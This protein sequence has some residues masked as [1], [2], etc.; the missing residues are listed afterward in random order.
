MAAA[1]HKIRGLQMERPQL[2]EIS[3]AQAGEF[4]Q[5]EC[6]RLAFRFAGLREPVEGIE[7]PRLSGFEDSL[8][9]GIQSVCSP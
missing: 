5:Q 3:G 7:G 1:A 8:Y 6:E 9:P 2:L 4:I